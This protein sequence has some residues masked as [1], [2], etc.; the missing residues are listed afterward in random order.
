M[1]NKTKIVIGVSA[2]IVG[3]GLYF[4]FMHKAK[5]GMTWYE[6]VTKPSVPTVKDRA[7]AISV[8]EQGLTGSKIPASFG[9]DYVIAWANALLAKEEFFFLAGKKYFTKTGRQA[10]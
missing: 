1:E 7:G 8:I 6:R 9:D 4:G 3:V 5:D 2:I 10:S